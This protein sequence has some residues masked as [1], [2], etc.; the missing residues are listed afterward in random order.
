MKKPNKWWMIIRG[1]AILIFIGGLILHTPKD[2]FHLFM[3]IV[4]VIIWTPW[5]LSD[6]YNYYQSRKNKA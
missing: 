3:S 5:F 1:T 4:M 2:D 6:L